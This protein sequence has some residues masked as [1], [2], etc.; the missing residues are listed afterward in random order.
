MFKNKISMGHPEGSRP[1]DSN[2]F[3]DALDRTSSKALADIHDIYF[4][5]V[6]RYTYGGVERTYGNC[7]GIE[8][9]DEQVDALFRVQENMGIPISLTLNQLEIPSE[10][11][12][13]ESVLDEFIKF[14]KSYYDRGLRS[15]TVSN[16]HLMSTR[17]LHSEFPEMRWKNTVNHKVADA[18]QMIEA[19][20]CG[21]DTIQLDRSLN[22]NIP[23]LKKMRIAAD[24]LI[25]RFPKRKK[26]SLSMLVKESCLYSCPFKT[27][28]D[29]LGKE[30]GV[31]YFNG[32]SGI[33][34]DNW[35]N[36]TLAMLPR[37][38]L[39][40]ET[41][42]AESL[43]LVSS[44]VDVFKHSGRFSDP[45]PGSKFTWL[46]DDA[47]LIGDSMQ[48]IVD[49]GNTPLQHWEFVSISLDGYEECNHITEELASDYTSPTKKLWLSDAGKKLEE[50]LLSCKSQCWD[51]HKCED[52]FGVPD[53]LSLLPEFTNR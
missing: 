7:M 34:C 15:C 30:I 11:H 13:D 21:Y 3:Y 20:Y 35:R 27:E 39:N 31:R 19:Y 25:A 45:Q 24:M 37:A 33:S 4:G 17:I 16:I 51:C 2:S 10:M 42:S 46:L 18:Q 32:M 8:A 6:F 53:I 43:R 12:L 47:N 48:D 9:T 5:K 28:H 23:E 1:I 44:L 29:S 41:V 26:L 52:V 14:I 36:G 38:G 49:A 50:T 22:R 40:I